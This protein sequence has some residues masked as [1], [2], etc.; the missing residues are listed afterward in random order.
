MVW[1]VKKLGDVG[2]IFSGNSINAKIKKE[3]YLH[4]E[5]GMPYIATKDVSYDSKIDYDNGVKIPHDQLDKF[6]IAHKNSIF[7]CAEGGSAGRKLAFNT[8]DVCFVNKLFALEPS[9]FMEPRYVFY[10][11]QTSDFQK[12]FYSRMTG[13]IGGVS[14]G[15][16][17]NI[18]IPVPPL[19]IQKKIVK[20]LDEAFEKLSKAKENAETNLN[21][22]KEVF[23]SYLQS[24][25]ENLRDKSSSESLGKLCHFVRGPFGGSLKKSSFKPSG[26][27]V[28]E[29][30]HAINNQ[31]SSIRYFIDEDKFEEMKRF[32]L[33]YGDLIMSCSGTMGKIAIVPENIKRGIINQA[34]LKLTPNKN[35]N[36]VFLKTWMESQ[37]FQE[38]IKKFS[39]GAAI[40][41]VASVKVLKEI[42]MPL[43][44]LEEQ[45]QIVAKLDN[46]S[47]E[48]KK[49][50]QIYNQKLTDL[51]ELKKS[52]LQKAFNGELTK[53]N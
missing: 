2:N 29:Q 49:L 26:F 21:N 32:E 23:E 10:F 44:L 11:Y 31:F 3:K 14:M 19:P 36:I 28:Y 1:E 25:F 38:Q 6:R 39:K 41:N 37:D 13:L 22:S 53:G 40:K 12:Q 27:A 18:N 8:E 47:A 45:K 33:K 46:L 51:E 24:V 43:P 30:Q 5:E 16:F 52:I 15:K 20:I 35:L 7:I 17:K 48:T 4:L 50:E 34:L 42:N 9:G